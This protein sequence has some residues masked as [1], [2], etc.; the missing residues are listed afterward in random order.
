MKSHLLAL[1]AVTTLVLA[2][3]GAPS[4]PHFV[5]KAALTDMYEVE[6]G[7]IASEKGQSKAVKEFGRQMV[8]AHSKTG[9]ELRG[10]VQAEKLAVKLPARLDKKHRKMI[11]ALREAKVE[12]F[13][14]TYLAQ[15]VKAQDGAAELFDSYAEEGGNAAL[16]QFAANTLQAIN[17]HREQAEEL[18]R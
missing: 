11:A 12:D 9:E 16:K 6:A 7:K 8:E 13:D 4:T 3:C 10:I 17:Q 2:S 14:E 15:Q 1:L 18:A 5:T